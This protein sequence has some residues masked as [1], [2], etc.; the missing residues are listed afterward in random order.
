MAAFG[1][2]WPI[3]FDNFVSRNHAKLSERARNPTARVAET[4]MPTT[5]PA[6]G[7]ITS[8]D[9]SVS[10]STIFAKRVPGFDYVA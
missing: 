8:M 1:Q 7:E 3:G 9:T 6:I 4:A 10:G 2:K 5:A